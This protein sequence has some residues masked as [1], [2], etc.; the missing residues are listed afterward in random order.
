MSLSLGNDE[1]DI[2]DQRSLDFVLSLIIKEKGDP[3]IV[4]APHDS[5]IKGA[6]SAGGTLPSKAGATSR[7]LRLVTPCVAAHFSLLP[8][9]RRPLRLARLLPQLRRLRRP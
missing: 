7:H 4:V 8:Q 6:S 9:F 5:A 2:T 3:V 1:I